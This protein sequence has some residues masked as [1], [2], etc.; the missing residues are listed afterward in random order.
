MGARRL[1]LILVVPIL[2]A[3][4]QAS[5]GE[6]LAIDLI[7]PDL[8]VLV[9]V[10]WSLLAGASE[11]IW[12][13]FVGGLAADLLSGS[14][15]GVITVSILPVAVV[16]GLGDRSSFQPTVLRGAGLIALAALLHELL[17]ALA[18]LLVGRA[19][20][21]GLTLLGVGLGAA[22]Y[23]GVVALAVFPPMR[24]LHRRTMRR[25]AFDW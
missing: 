5:V 12:W 23:T 17:Y 20:P 6:H 3:V 9:V 18:V 19:L 24:A 11:S 25:P 15:F 21:D 10:S 2:A 4:V 14:A 7:R 22:A 1:L 16:F 8:L 13:A